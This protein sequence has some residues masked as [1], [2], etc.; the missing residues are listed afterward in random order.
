M[1][2]VFTPKILCAAQ[3]VPHVYL[4]KDVDI[5]TVT[6]LLQDLQEQAPELSLTDMLLQA[7]GR[8]LREVPEANAHYAGDGAT[9]LLGD[10][11]VA[12]V[13]RTPDTGVSVTVLPGLDTTGIVEVVSLRSA[14]TTSSGMA[15][16]GVVFNGEG[17]ALSQDSVFRSVLPPGLTGLVTVGGTGQVVGVDSNGQPTLLTSLRLSLTADARVMDNALAAEFLACVG[18]ELSNL[19]SRA[20]RTAVM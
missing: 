7:T 4:D 2:L 19:P 12:L 3:S 10:A 1:R 6:S 14:A 11:N 18:D 20:L 15:A 5:T 8:A 16:I 17:D 13:T 9:S